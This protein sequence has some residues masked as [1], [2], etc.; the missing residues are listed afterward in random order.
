MGVR[1]GGQEGSSSATQRLS[2]VEPAGG[3][4][5]ITYEDGTSKQALQLWCTKIT[6][7][8]FSLQCFSFLACLVVTSP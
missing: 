3:A 6:C 8:L 1:L 5:D 4:T 2:W 7:S